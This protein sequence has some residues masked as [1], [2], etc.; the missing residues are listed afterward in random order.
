MKKFTWQGQSIL[1]GF[2]IVLCLFLVLF[3]FSPAMQV[4]NNIPNVVYLDSDSQ[5]NDFFSSLPAPFNYSIED[6]TQTVSGSIDES[7]NKNRTSATVELF[8]FIPVKTVFFYTKSNHYLIPCGQSIG[9]ALHTKGILVVGTSDITTTSSDGTIKN[10]PSPAA[11]AGIVAGDII[12]E[13]NG[14]EIYNTD[15]LVEICNS[16]NGQVTL[17]IKRNKNPQ[18]ITLNAAYDSRENQYKLGM[19]VRDSTAGIGTISFFDPETLN[20]AAL[21][22]A[23]MD[24]DTSTVFDVKSGEITECEIVDIIKGEV[25]EAG[26]LLGTFGSSSERF[27]SI[28][29]N[30][31]FGVYGTLYGDMDIDSLSY[32]N[33]PLPVAFP[34]EVRTGKATILTTLNDSTIGEYECK[35]TKLFSQSKAE[36]KGFVIE[37]TDSRLLEK[38]GGIV[39]GMSGSPIIQNGKIIGV[40]THV[41]INDPQRGYCMYAYWMAELMG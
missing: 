7:L 8:G 30:C 37:I 38:T 19:W 10:V 21:G 6:D 5:K 17:T 25:G 34:S 18:T 28:R 20:Y 26:E 33:Q 1:K 22:H 35:V 11:V 39:Q 4:I 15:N 36:S 14:V 16:A 32:Y 13:A 40:V 23:I 31:E 2:G 12:T 27:G 3:N 24:I 9:I 29:T 41:M